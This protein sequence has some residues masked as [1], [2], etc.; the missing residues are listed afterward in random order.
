M[1]VYIVGVFLERYFFGLDFLL[2]IHFCMMNRNLVCS[3][4]SSS[5]DVLDE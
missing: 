4:D 3:V 1:N 5:G 2:Y